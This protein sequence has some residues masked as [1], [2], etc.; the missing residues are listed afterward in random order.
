[1]LNKKKFVVLAALAGLTAI[2]ITAMRPADDP[3]GPKNLK[4][5]PKHISHDDLMKTMDSWRTALGVKCNFCH[6]ASADSTAHRLDFA[7]DAKPEKNIARGMYKMAIKI[8]KKFFK[9]IKD[10]QGQP[11]QVVTCKTCH[12]GSPHPNEAK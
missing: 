7:S 6:A 8:N 5:L 10:D 2:G 3:P 9:K 11:M 12:H 1:M 4:V